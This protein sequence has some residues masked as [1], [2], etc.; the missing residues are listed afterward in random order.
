MCLYLLKHD[1]L[2]YFKSFGLT[3]LIYLMLSRGMLQTNS[4]CK[5]LV[6]HFTSEI[7]HEDKT[8]QQ[9]SAIAVSLES[10]SHSYLCNTIM[11]SPHQFLHLPHLLQLF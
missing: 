3:M 7:Q 10:L 6:Q 4:V 11:S 8:H 2:I 1:N 9:L 5:H